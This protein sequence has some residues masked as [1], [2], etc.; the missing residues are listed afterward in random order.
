MFSF[1]SHIELG[2]DSNFTRK[3]IKLI[4]L[5]KITTYNN[6]VG[7]QFLNQVII[8]QQGSSVTNCS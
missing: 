8:E 4:H 5:R 3:I 2:N 6:N 7:S 1:L